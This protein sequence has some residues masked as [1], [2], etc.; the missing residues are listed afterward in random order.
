MAGQVLVTPFDFVHRAQY[1]HA[2]DT[3]RRLLELG[4]IPIVNENDTVADD[5]IRFGD[6]DRIAALVAN[7]VRAEM[8]VL[9]TDTAGPVHRGS[10]A[11]R[12]RIAH[13]RGRRGRRGARV[14]RRGHGLG[15]GER[16]HGEQ[17][18][19]GEDR[20]VVRCARGDRRGRPAGSAR[21]TRS[22]GVAV[23]TVVQPHAERLPSRKL[24]IAFAVGAGGRV[25]VDD[26]ARRAL[27]SQGRSLLA[28][29]VRDVEGDF[30]G[31]RRG[32]DRRR[33]R[34]RV[35]EGLQRGT[36]PKGLRAVAGRRSG[37]LPDG[38]PAEVDPP[39]RPRRA[40]RL[41]AGRPRPV[42]HLAHGSW[43]KFAK[44]RGNSCLDMWRRSH[45]AWFSPAGTGGGLV[46]PPLTERIRGSPGPR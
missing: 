37:D 38:S 5:E 27:V 11:R 12:R 16:R 10:A 29:G 14:R 2:R 22:A 46:R 20:V 36:R 41:T 32:R 25:I 13:R 1:L 18:R 8:L 17:A 4:V 35:R 24:W 19:R 34:S 45:C 31:G 30:D 26:G 21:P 23:G 15:A 43:S 3:L 44:G 9:L 42:S 6:N 40:G 33:G 7:M 39:R 28:A